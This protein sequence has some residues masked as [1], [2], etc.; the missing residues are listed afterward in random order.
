MALP[1]EIVVN[2]YVRKLHPERLED[3]CRTFPEVAAKPE[4]HAEL[5]SNLHLRG[6]VF[7]LLNLLYK[8]RVISDT[9]TTLSVLRLVE[10]EGLRRLRNHE[11]YFDRRPGDGDRFL[12]LNHSIRMWK[13]ACKALRKQLVAERTPKGTCP[14]NLTSD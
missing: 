3:W 4:I 8:V 5:Q 12:P 10:E 9:N 13:D 1:T 14:R 2:G 6:T 11:P 7:R